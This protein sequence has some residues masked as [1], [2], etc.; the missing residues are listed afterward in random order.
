MKKYVK[1]SLEEL[2]TNDIPLFIG[3]SSYASDDDSCY[4]GDDGED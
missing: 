3:C 1:P 4:Y 2:N